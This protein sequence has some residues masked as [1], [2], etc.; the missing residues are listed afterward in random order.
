MKIISRGTIHEQVPHQSMCR[1]CYTVFEWM[2]PE[3]RCHSD[4][5]DGDYYSIPCPVCSREV[6]KQVRRY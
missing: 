2:T 5:R 4:Q 3:A 1:H 6:T